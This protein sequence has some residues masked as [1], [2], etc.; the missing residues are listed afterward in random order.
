MTRLHIRGALGAAALLTCASG[1][2]AHTTLERREAEPNAAFKAVVQINHGCKGSPTTAVTVTIPDGM[3]AARAMPKP[4]WT[5]STSRGAYSRPYPY[6]GRE[7][8]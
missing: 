8:A 6:F 3:I 7:L 2:L 5:L 1:T 4:G